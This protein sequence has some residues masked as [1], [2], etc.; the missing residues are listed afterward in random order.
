MEKRK[1]FQATPHD[2]EVRETE[3]G[4]TVLRG[5]AAVFNRLS[6]DLGGFRERVLPGAFARTLKENPDVRAFISHDPARVVGRT[7]SGTLTLREDDKGLAVRMVLPDT[8]DGRDLAALV[9][10][11]DVDQ[12]SFGFRVQRENWLLAE[13]AKDDD[14]DG[15]IRELVDVDLFEVS[16][17]AMP[18]YDETD[19][20]VRDIVHAQEQRKKTA[21]RLRRLAENLRIVDERRNTA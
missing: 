19:L 12:M 8:T 4:E 7:K 13:R 15:D 20:A 16:A 14:Y 21:E 2:F 3:D 5:H 6:Q 18:A 17:V 10:R 1:W 9:Q 11:G